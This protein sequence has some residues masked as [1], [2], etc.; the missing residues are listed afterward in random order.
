MGSCVF[1]GI[2]GLLTCQFS[3]RFFCGSGE[4][5][6]GQ[7]YTNNCDNLFGIQG[8]CCIPSGCCQPTTLMHCNNA[9][10][11]YAGNGNNINCVKPVCPTLPPTTVSPTTATPTTTAPTTAN[12]TTMTPTTTAPTTANPTTMT[13]TTNAPTDSSDSDSD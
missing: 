6:I 13:P 8:G 11:S 4:T 3:A 7:K 5:Q 12:P 1:T 10:G 2:C 9:F